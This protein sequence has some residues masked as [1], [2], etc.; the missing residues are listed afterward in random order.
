MRGTTSGPGVVKMHLVLLSRFYFKL[1]FV[2]FVSVV[3]IGGDLFCCVCLGST[4]GGPLC[5]GSVV[6][7]HWGGDVV[8]FV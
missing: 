7:V 3:V 8:S 4:Y 1:F 5:P 2:L 6:G